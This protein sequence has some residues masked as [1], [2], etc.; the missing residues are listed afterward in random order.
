MHASIYPAGC[1][2]PDACMNHQAFGA[3]LDSSVCQGTSPDDGT[4]GCRALPTPD[5][6][7]HV[8]PYTEAEQHHLLIFRGWTAHGP[9]R[10][11]LTILC[12]PGVSRSPR[13]SQ[14]QL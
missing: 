4:G 1:V 13:F 12:R 2:G 7:G 5:H 3:V 9:A 14:A 10:P 6:Q 11:L 8:T